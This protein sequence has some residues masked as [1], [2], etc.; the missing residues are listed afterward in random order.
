MLFLG[1]ILQILAIAKLPNGVNADDNENNRNQGKDNEF[2]ES[3]HACPIDQ[4][5]RNIL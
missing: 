1:G 2:F 4:S 3:T 5:L